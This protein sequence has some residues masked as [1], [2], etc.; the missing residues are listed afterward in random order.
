VLAD[1]PAAGRSWCAS[2]IRASTWSSGF[3]IA[4][5]QEGSLNIK[6]DINL[7]IWQV[8][9]GQGIEI[10][11]PQ[12]EVRL[13]NGRT[14]FAGNT[15]SGFSEVKSA[16]RVASPISGFQAMLFSGTFDLPWWGYVARHPGPDPRHHRRR[17]HL[18]APPPGS[19]R[20]RPASLPSH[21]FR[22]WLWLTTGMVTKEWAAIHR[23]HHAKCETADDPHSPQVNWASTACCGA[24]CSFT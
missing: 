9:Q 13:R 21:F 16:V 12:R 20:A 4:D 5:P 24:A 10:P 17:H 11:Y 3:W 18:P 14:R 8:P 19:P 6:S 2:P 7:E 22:F 15:K 1:P 23:K